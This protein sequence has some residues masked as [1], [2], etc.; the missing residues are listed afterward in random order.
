MPKIIPDLA[1]RIL[2]VTGR[3]FETKGY[4][5]TDMK[6]LAAEVGISV[7]TLY[8]YY[9]SKPELF[10]E[11]CAHWKQKLGEKMLERLDR[12]DGANAK[13]RDTL[14][15]LFDDMVNYTG[16]W[17]EF[18]RSGALRPG[19]PY[20]DRFRKDNEALNHRIQSLFQEVWKGHPGVHG[21]V[22]DPEGRLGQ[23]MVGSIMQLA[24]NVGGD[25]AANRQF[26]VHWLDFV[27]PTWP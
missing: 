10:V 18:Q 23:L 1:A 24:M 22:D 20:G 4:D 2:E 13:L 14:L 17:R 25:P 16:I 9:A 8:N 15:M 3:S 7:G 12:P 21:I 27:V 11:V 19:T 5:G 26:V 6:S